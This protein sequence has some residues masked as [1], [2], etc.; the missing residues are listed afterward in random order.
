MNHYH[1]LMH[2]RLLSLDTFIKSITDYS[3]NN[4]LDIVH[5]VPNGEIKVASNQT[6]LARNP[7]GPG[8]RTPPE[9]ATTP[10]RHDDDLAGE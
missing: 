9:V 8:R 10:R 5:T 2:T 3:R 6:R 4:R 1:K 7:D